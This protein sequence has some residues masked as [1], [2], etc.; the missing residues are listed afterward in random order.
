[1]KLSERD[2]ENPYASPGRSET[3]PPIEPKGRPRVFLASFLGMQAGGLLGLCSG[4]IAPMRYLLGPTP[5]D[6][7]F[8]EDISG[9]ATA[10][11]IGETLF[12]II[13]CLV[14]GMTFGAI[15][16]FGQKFL[17][18]KPLLRDWFPLSALRIRALSRRGIA[19][20]IMCSA[21]AILFFVAA[22]FRQDH[23][24]SL[25]ATWA[26][27]HLL[28]SMYFGERFANACRRVQRVNA[29]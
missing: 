12:V 11:I 27:A 15:C 19:F 3:L 9:D 26:L 5:L 25:H 8:L 29:A 24:R 2:D 10:Q 20:A 17:Y 14:L 23:Y 6:A 18:P 7:V 1:M 28:L 13:S 4:I 22:M 16:E 21:P